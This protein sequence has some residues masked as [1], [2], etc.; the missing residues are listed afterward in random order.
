MLKAQ[1]DPVL[2]GAMDSAEGWRGEW[3][4]KVG[5]EGGEDVFVG[6]PFHKTMRA[7]EI[8]LELF[9]QYNSLAA[10]VGEDPL[11]NLDEVSMSP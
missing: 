7:G 10:A 8:R 4:V 1:A 2:Q 3:A 9:H 5:V 11:N 6:H